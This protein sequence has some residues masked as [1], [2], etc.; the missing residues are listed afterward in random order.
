M[1]PCDGRRFLVGSAA[2]AL[3]E[4]ALVFPLLLTLALGLLQVTLYVHARDVLM[5]AA[6]EGA[7]LAAE[8]GRTLEDGFARVRAVAQAG[9]GDAVEP[10]EPRGR[11]DDDLVEIHLE[12]A[13][14]SI[15][16]LPISSGLPIQVHASVS[17]E[18]FRPG[19][20]GR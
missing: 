1:R 17:R 14:R 3:V 19:G 15:V 7:R 10:F 18:R 20:G 8:D 12:S 13:L 2:Q 16:P 6:Q 5:T 11:M 4:T 9:L